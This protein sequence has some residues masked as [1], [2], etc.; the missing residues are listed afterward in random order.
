MNHLASSFYVI[1]FLFFGQ[2]RGVTEFKFY[3]GDDFSPTSS[4]RDFKN[5]SSEMVY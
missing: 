2:Q 3:L 4:E 5:R 1:V